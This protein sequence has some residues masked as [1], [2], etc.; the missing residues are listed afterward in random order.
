MRCGWGQGSVLGPANMGVGGCRGARWQAWLARYGHSAVWGAS[1]WRHGAR[2]RP[3]GKPVARLRWLLSAGAS[4]RRSSVRGVMPAEVAKGV[5]PIHWESVRGVYAAV[6]LGGVKPDHRVNTKGVKPDH[7][8][9]A[10][11][12]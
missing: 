3:A 1:T 4:G 9:N 10:R 6:S 12:V 8:E 11:G 5:K 7:R 2:G